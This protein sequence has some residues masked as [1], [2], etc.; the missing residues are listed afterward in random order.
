MNTRKLSRYLSRWCKE[1]GFDVSVRYDTEF[2]FWLN[3]NV[4]TYSFLVSDF[5][6]KTFQKVFVKQGLEY[7]CDIFIL[8]FFHELGHYETEDEWTEKQFE[9]FMKQKDELDANKKADLWK[10]YYMPDEIRATQWATDYINENAD[11]VAKFW[12]KVK[13]L[14][15]EIYDEI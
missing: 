11:E 4:V 8:S 2:A 1:H 14:I 3:K 12:Q 10:Y 9:R 7:N 15:L 5:H 13:P 6:D